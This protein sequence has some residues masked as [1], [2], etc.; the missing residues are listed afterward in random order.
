MPVCG[1]SMLTNDWVKIRLY[2]W[3]GSDGCVIVEAQRRAG[4]AAKSEIY[5]C[6]RNP[7]DAAG[8]KYDGREMKDNEDIILGYQ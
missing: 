7:L 5:E 1:A 8:R 4:N 2:L 6:I 3:R